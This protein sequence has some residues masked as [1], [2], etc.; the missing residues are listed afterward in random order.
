MQYKESIYGHNTKNQNI[1]VAQRV[2]V[3]MQHMKSGYRRS[4]KSQDTD[5]YMQH[6]QSIYGRNTKNQ[7]IDIAQR[8]KVKMQHK[9]ST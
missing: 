3:K 2:E 4:A 1:D 8:V 5:V 9:E 6:K 7:N